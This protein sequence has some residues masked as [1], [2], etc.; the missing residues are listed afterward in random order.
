MT[1]RVLSVRLQLEV[2]A[3]RR[4]AK[5][6]AGDLRNVGSAA[7]GAGKGGIAS[8]TGLG[9]A[10][11]SAGKAAATVG[12]LAAGG[13]AVTTAAVLKGGMAYNTL[14]QTSRAAL[15]TLLGS[16]SA[17]TNQMEALREFGKTS[18]FPRQVW[19]AAQQQLLAFGM[20]AEKIIP[21]FQ[22]IQDGVAAA[23]GGGQQ[24]SEVVDILAKVQ[25]TGKVGADTLNEL[26][27][28]GID[29]A[30]LIGEAMGKTAAEVRADISAQAISGVDFIDQ[31][32]GAM[33]LRFGGA[34][35]GVKATWAGATDRIKGAVRDIGGLLASG[36]I[37]PEGGGAAVDWANAVADALRA[38]ESRLEP[39]MTAMRDRA[40]PIFDAITEKLQ[41]LASWIRTA[42]FAELGHR[43]QSML[44]AIVG[45]TAGFT[46][47]GA[48][49]L[50]IV[51]QL[52]SGLKP[53]PVAL[54]AAAL[55]SPELRQ[56]LVELL[57]AAA[58][59]LTST[60]QLT[61]TLA[62]ALGP[63]LSAV[64]A[65]MQPII[66]VV[67][68]L[69]D[70]FSDL[71]GLIQMVVVGFIAWKAL[72][73]G[74][75]LTQ[76]VTALRA[77]GE[78]MKV[79]QALAAM[80]GQ[81][82][83]T[84]GAAYSVA[85][86]RVSAAGT[87]I[88]ATGASVRGALASAAGFL[89]GPWG[90][91][92]GLGVAALALF[93]TTQEGATAAAE[94]FNIQIERGTG[95][96]T[97]GSIESI[98]KWAAGAETLTNNGA[99]LSDVLKD[100]GLTADDLTG[101]LTG[102][103]EATE[104]VNAALASH[105]SAAERN[106]FKQFLDISKGKIDD[107]TR[108]QLEAAAAGGKFAD[109][110]EDGANTAAGASAAYSG[111]AG[112]LGAVGSATDDVATRTQQLNTVL[113]SIY[114]T[115]F[116]L[117][118]SSDKFQGGLNALKNAFA[119]N[120]KA[121][122]KSAGSADKYSDSIKR[123]QKIVRDTTKQLQ[124]LAEAQ[125]KAEE[126]A[127]EAAKNARQR[128]LDELFGKTF[129][130]QATADA[131]QQALAQAG[132][133]IR[134]SSVAG[135]RDLSGFSE[136]ALSNRERMRGLVQA[137]QA[138]I[139]AERDQGA[140]KQRIAQ[141]TA[142][143]SGQLDAQ[144]ASWGLN[145]AEVKQYSDAVRGFGSLALQ[146]VI[147]DLSQVRKEYA[148]QRKEIQENSREQMD[149]ARA[150]AASAS[151]AGGAASATKIH[152]AALTGNS[153]SAIENR[154][155]MQD[156]VKAAQDELAQMH[157]NGAG[158]E[159]LTA[160]GEEQ[161]A[162][163]EA[164][165]IQLG[166]STTDMKIYTDAIRVSAQEVAKY[167]VLT[168]R[169]DT[170]AALAAVQNFVNGV[171]AQMTRI[172]KNFEIGVY[173]GSEYINSRAG[174]KIPLMNAD[175]G[176][177]AGPGGPREDKILS[178]L[179]NGEYV[180]NAQDT[181]KNRPLLERI[182]SGREPLPGFAA[183]GHVDP[184]N[185]NFKGMPSTG[186]EEMYQGIMGALAPI[187]AYAAGPVRWAA[188]Q[189]GKPYIWGGVGPAGYDCSGFQS[190]ITNV[191]Q[192]RAPYS[193]RFATGSFPTGDFLKGPGNYSIGYFRGNPGHMAGTLNGV[194]VESRG[195]E[196]VVVGK[197]AR[198]AGDGLF[199]GNIW[200]LKGYKDGGQVGTG[201]DPPFDLISPLGKHFDRLIKGSY[202]AGTDYVPMDGLYQLHRGEAVT[203]AAQNGR[204][205]MV[206]EVRSD[207]SKFGDL[208]VE[209]INKA[210]AT[211]RIR[212]VRR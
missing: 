28:R 59:L 183:G 124:D 139:Q 115:Q 69:A 38:L 22:A 173:T 156:Q 122:A 148:D 99:H 136:G 184:M 65:L 29:A 18:P 43:I 58:P 84:M 192:G 208:V 138:T 186:L 47:M 207:G 190:A 36:L 82:I 6:L 108:V 23:G 56:A 119:G 20:S 180:V 11:V 143:L 114:D 187:A 196:G 130:V 133:D 80:S 177:I 197:R 153:E 164:L 147:V 24:I 30:T 172:Q 179:S 101:Y 127:A 154:K 135:A 3:A 188:S 63:A 33:E 54:A 166:F 169:A 74:T 14:E 81:Q 67:G 206:L 210:D 91:A 61:T 87:S 203:P 112:M 178:W 111:L 157:L 182:N 201:G 107:Q 110:T 205:E 71:P 200:H 150:S 41:A 98:Y 161:A 109:S 10:A 131:F 7:D 50:P 158:S 51:G 137:A 174:G 193:R 55:A 68:F 160:K 113:G 202:A 26:G 123:Q 212:L 5:E 175:G 45:V 39:V 125:K 121:A 32:T 199:G 89:A 152:T 168:A 25:S 64:A 116:A 60:A 78:Q 176:Y 163:L 85:A 189:A 1:D 9:R 86:T 8:L 16:A 151:A 185:L 165:G 204:N 134:G 96:L 15:A 181:A 46:A 97:A 77:F 17:A 40:G 93:S 76:N 4:A 129:N 66:A 144:A 13:M 195:G 44:P 171:N 48:K 52:V 90:A 194:N 118:S 117:Q 105:D 88:A 140:S 75:W 149:N 142:D 94:E 83:G 42:D 21:T 31:L 79:Q 159:E 170:A 49:S 100:F 72:G 62:G 27:Y 70:R 132:S 2:A 102:N 37:A 120:D 73:I 128:A 141:V 155:M 19:I 92:I 146:D 12:G 53:L 95:A 35:A 191:I 34:A 103:A 104:K 209:S 198:G 57:S 106:S 211:G 145:T 162:Q 126:E 167:P